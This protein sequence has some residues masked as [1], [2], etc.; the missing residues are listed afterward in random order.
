VERRNSAQLRRRD[1]K[2]SADVTLA[3]VR[4]RG[5]LDDFVRAIATRSSRVAP[6]W[7][8]WPRRAGG[9]ESDL[10][11]DVVRAAGLSLGLVDTKV[12]AVD[13]D[14]SGLRFSKRWA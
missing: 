7:L 12:A 13:R 1:P 3:F 14:W 10:T 5:G 9:H 6:L 11:D 2:T 8:C 4:D